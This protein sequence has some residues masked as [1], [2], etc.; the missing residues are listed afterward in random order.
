MLSGVAIRDLWYIYTQVYKHLSFFMEIS[1][2]WFDNHENFLKALEKN[3]L[4]LWD[5]IESHNI[6]ESLP[7]PCWNDLIWIHNT[8]LNVQCF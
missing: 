8:L 4:S 1:M 5:Y 3:V 7:K 6:S 2:F